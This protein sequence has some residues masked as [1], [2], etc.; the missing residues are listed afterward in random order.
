M[1]CID[2]FSITSEGVI[3]RPGGSVFLLP[4]GAIRPAPSSSSGMANFL[5]LFRIEIYLISI[6]PS[7]IKLVVVLLST[8]PKVLRPGSKNKKYN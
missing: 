6:R 4:L 7:N 5:G 3:C 8:K 1:S 2:L